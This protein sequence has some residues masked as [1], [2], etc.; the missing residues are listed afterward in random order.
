[1]DPGSE[2]DNYDISEDVKSDLRRMGITAFTPLQVMTVER[3]MGGHVPL[4]HGRRIVTH[5]A[6][7]DVLCKAEPGKMHSPSLR[8]TS[9]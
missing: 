9:S 4:N 5:A 1:M 2:L 7:I 8:G 3:Y 6:K